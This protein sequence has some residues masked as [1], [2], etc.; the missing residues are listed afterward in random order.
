MGLQLAE[1]TEASDRAISDAGLEQS[2]GNSRGA[3]RT[4]RGP[5]LAHRESSSSSFWA[6]VKDPELTLEIKSRRRPG[7]APEEARVHGQGEFEDTLR[8]EAG[9]VS[10]G[11]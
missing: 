6:R 10:R 4:G 1:A 7:P 8:P 11:P 2:S 3:G 9:Q 5:G